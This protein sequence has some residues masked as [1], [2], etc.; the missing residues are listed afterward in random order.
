MAPN[1]PRIRSVSCPEVRHWLFFY[2]K[3]QWVHYRS[4]VCLAK[5]LRGHQVRAVWMQFEDEDGKLSKPR[6]LIST[7]SKLSADELCKAY[8]RRWAIED[9]F[10]QM[11]NGW[12][13]RE[14]WQQS[15][16]GL[17]RWPQ[18]LSAAYAL[19]QLLSMYCSEQM[20]G[21]LQLT[22]WRKKAPM[23]AGQIR[24]GLRMFFSH[25]Q[26]RN[27][28]SPTCRKFEPSSA[29]GK[30]DNTADSQKKCPETE[31][32]EQQGNSSGPAVMTMA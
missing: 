15:R 23:T 17:H 10:N 29:L 11:K 13:W 20:H 31:S 3:W 2:G 28:W 9:L 27:W 14:A 19:P 25:V 6:L 1:T 5:F 18:I 8:A 30:P 26:V 7:N 4:A 16:Q 21:L 12:G 32:K 24:L 22:P